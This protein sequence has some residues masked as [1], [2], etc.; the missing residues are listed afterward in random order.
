M[1]ASRN[2]KIKALLWALLIVIVG[3]IFVWRTGNLGEPNFESTFVGRAFDYTCSGTGDCKLGD[4]M[5]C[6]QVR[7]EFQ[8]ERPGLE[9]IDNLAYYDLDISYPINDECVKG[10]L[11]L[12]EDGSNILAVCLYFS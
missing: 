4:G 9:D 2:E 11:V 12:F 7:S 8:C 10:E 3:F 1:Y 6:K 5:V